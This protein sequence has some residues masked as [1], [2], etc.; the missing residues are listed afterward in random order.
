L[1][2]SVLLP[3]CKQRTNYYRHMMIDP[4]T[5]TIRLTD[6]FPGLYFGADGVYYWQFLHTD[7]RVSIDHF[8]KTSRRLQAIRYNAFFLD[9][10]NRL[11]TRT[12][13]QEL[14]QG[15]FG[16]IYAKTT[17]F[18]ADMYGEKWTD[19]ETAPYLNDVGSEPAQIV[20]KTPEEAIRQLSAVS[21]I[22]VF[23]APPE[24]LIACANYSPDGYLESLS[25]H[26][27]KGGDWVHT[28]Y[29][30]GTGRGFQV[31]RSIGDRPETRELFG[32]PREFPLVQYQSK[33][34]SPFAAT[35]YPGAMDVVNFHHQR[36]RW[37]EQDLFPADGPRSHRCLIFK[38]TPED[39][40]LEPID[41]Q[42]LFGQFP[43]TRTW[44]KSPEGA[45]H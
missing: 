31:G 23:R 18:Y 41:N 38:V 28:N 27:S 33:R 15:P 42:R 9:P 43:Y 19:F 24:F 40:T 36:N 21:V 1:L 13:Y 34:E 6:W 5:L 3:A 26:G 20:E 35:R 44:K 7:G 16:Q 17:Y 8:E 2:A 4:A 32:L 12:K 37:V 30:G 25:V 11:I 39:R 10:Q 22:R 29:L 45:T 14:L